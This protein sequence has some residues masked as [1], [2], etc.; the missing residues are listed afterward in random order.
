LFLP[1]ADAYQ[2][3]LSRSWSIVVFYGIFR[4]LGPG[5]FLSLMENK[6]INLAKY[7]LI[8]YRSPPIPVNHPAE[9]TVD[10]FFL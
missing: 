6:V 1:L 4:G 7:S 10:S 3:R 8:S 5:F 9:I 2:H